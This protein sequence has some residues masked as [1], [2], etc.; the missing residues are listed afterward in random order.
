MNITNHKNTDTHAFIAEGVA[1]SKWLI[2]L[3]VI[4]QLVDALGN[5]V[6]IVLLGRAINAAV[7]RDAEAFWQNIG[8]YSFLTVLLIGQRACSRQLNETAASNVENA[9]KRRL[10]S[11]IMYGDFGRIAGVHSGEWMNRLS[12]DTALVAESVVQLLPGA[13]GTGVKIV[14]GVGLLFY[15]LPGFATLA[16]VGGVII[17]GIAVGFR[18]RLKMLHQKIREED[19]HVRMFAQEHI[20]SLLIVKAFGREREVTDRAVNKMQ[21]HKMARIKRMTISNLCNVGFAFAVNGAYLMGLVMCGQGILEGVL[22]YGTLA[23]VLKL[24]SQIQAPFANLTGYL[25]RYYA[26][27]ASADRLMEA[28]RQCEAEESLVP[29][30]LES[31]SYYDDQFDRLVFDRLSFA[32]TSDAWVLQE[33]SAV[34]GKGEFIAI[35]GTSG[36]G[37]STLLKLLLCIYPLQEGGIFLEDKMGIRRELTPAERKLF[38]YVPQGNQ[39]LSGSIRD[40]VYFYSP[41]ESQDESRLM[42]ALKV[43]CADEFVS[44]LPEGVDTELGEHGAGLSDGQLQ[45]LLIA[46]ALY[47]NRPV[48]LLDEATSALDETTERQVLENLRAMTDKTVLIVTHR[49]AALDVC[50]RVISL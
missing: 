10:F 32:Y 2:V 43:A 25:P 29:E 18:G 34:I 38:A 31:Q 45:R 27:L 19:G 30:S 49:S 20:E 11:K 50:D 9:F 17:G 21:R 7:A 47:A 23:T 6:L 39:L 13:V 5:L 28:E 4:L 1:K 35:T 40:A 44:A 8:Y 41:K 12:T 46:R 33:F 15:Y 24:I 26:M 14:G 3:L 48:L 22:S 36:R 42:W 16:V 37:K